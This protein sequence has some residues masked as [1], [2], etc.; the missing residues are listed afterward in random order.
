MRSKTLHAWENEANLGTHSAN[1]SNLRKLLRYLWLHCVVVGHVRSANAF[2]AWEGTTIRGLQ[3][4]SW[5]YSHQVACGHRIGYSAAKVISISRA[6]HPGGE[7]STSVLN[8]G[9]TVNQTAV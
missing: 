5:H 6:I 1:E 7:C 8:A 2:M 4:T 3:P 9:A